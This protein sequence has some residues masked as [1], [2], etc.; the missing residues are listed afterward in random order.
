MIETYVRAPYQRILVDPIASVLRERISPN[1]LTLLSGL[2]GIL[3]LPCLYLEAH[4]MAII[5]L[6]LSGFL[7][8]LDGTVA[9]LGSSASDWGSVLDIT[10]DRLVEFIIIFALWTI[11]PEVRGFWIIM[12]LGSV[13]L[14]IT[15]FLVVGIFTTNESDKGFYY[16]PGIMERAEAFAFFIA[17]I[18]WPTYFSMLAL[19]FS[20]LVLLTAIIRL[21]QFYNIQ[22]LKRMGDDQKNNQPALVE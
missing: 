13:L 5:L 22:Q 6:L 18:L 17:M 3:T 14:C 10:T 7:D 1:Q 4:F 21:K 12:M 16:S 11:A 2:V 19:L 15:S 8:T 9:R 20:F